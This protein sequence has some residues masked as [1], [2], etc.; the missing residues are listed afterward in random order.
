[1][2]TVDNIFAGYDQ[3]RVLEGASLSIGESEA[4]SIIGLNGA[5][6]TTLL[7]CIM[8]LVKISSG[9]ILFRG[10]SLR[11]LPTHRIAA[12][13]LNLV[14]ENRGIFKIL[15][16]EE[17]IAIAQKQESRWSVSDIY[18]MFPRLK[19]RRRSPGGK[20]SG[21]EQQML[22][23][24]RALVNAPELLLLDEPTEGLAPAIVNELKDVML[25]IKGAGVPIIIVEQNLSVC[26]AVADRHVI[27]ELGKTVAEY[28]ARE[29]SE[30]LSIRRRYL[31]V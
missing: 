7:K 4:V 13:G 2:L 18:E 10:R 5:G 1:M 26:D 31:M 9:D 3:S 30:D 28:S 15:S 27:L 23:I 6:R 14:P 8:G 11:G 24:A 22:A 29:F 16:V 21:G 17:N 25:R 19:E 20:L 12:L